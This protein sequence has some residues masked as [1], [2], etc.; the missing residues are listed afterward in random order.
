MENR[1]RERVG[2]KALIKRGSAAFETTRKGTAEERL[3][4][5][6]A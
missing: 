4:K 3:R 5:R 2:W 6:K 1:A